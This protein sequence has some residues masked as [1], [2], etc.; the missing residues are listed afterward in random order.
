MATPV[1]EPAQVEIIDR[2]TGAAVATSFAS[3][4]SHTRPA[5]TTA[6]AAGDVIGATDTNTAAAFAFAGIAPAAGADVIITSASLE[7]DLTAVP[8]GMTGFTLHLYSVTPPSAYVDNNAWDLPSGDRASY[9]GAISLGTPV[10]LGSTLFVEQ[11]GVN[12]QITAAGA[13]VYGYL[14]SAG[15][16]TPASGTVYKVTLHAI[17]A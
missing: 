6:Y 4:I 14:V 17:R 8:S 11:N 7:V 9:L 5:D 2:N 15:G 1:P 16:Y 10:D 12:K 13:T 3:A